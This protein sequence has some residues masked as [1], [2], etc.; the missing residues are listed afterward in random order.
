MRNLMP[1]HL[2]GSVYLG[3]IVALAF[4]LHH[5]ASPLLPFL[6]WFGFAALLSVGVWRWLE[7]KPIHWS[8]S[9]RWVLI[10]AL[11]FHAVAL[12]VPPFMEDDYFRYLWDGY[13]TYDTGQ[14]YGIPPQWYFGNETLSPRLQTL[15]DNINYPSIP[16]IYGPFAQ[17]LFALAYSLGEGALWA[18]RGIAFLFT[19]VYCLL[20]YRLFPG[21]RSI[22]LLWHPLLIREFS[23]AMH[24]DIVMGV[25]ML[26]A[27]WAWQKQQ[28]FR[29]GLTGAL[30][31]ATKVIAVPVV[32][33]LAVR[34]RSREQ[35]HQ[36]IVVGGVCFFALVGLYGVFMWQ[37]PASEWAGLWSFASGFE[38]NSSGYALLKWSLGIE[39]AR[40]ISYVL[41]GLGWLWVWFKLWRF[42]W[43]IPMALFWG[44]AWSWCWL[45]VVNPWYLVVWL[46]WLLSQ[47]A[48]WPW[49]FSYLIVLSY[50]TGMYW[51]Q[52]MPLPFTQQPLDLYQHPLWL[53][54]L[55]FL[56]VLLVG[57]WE[58]WRRRDRM[59]FETFQH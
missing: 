16:T 46:P 59:V 34:E 52:D 31:I 18:W 8:V 33:A 56:P 40:P 51:P 17:A 15:L 32:I 22:L 7:R 42:R 9:G 3:S 38:F 5:G 57:C 48:V 36:T 1:L 50:I 10:W 19:L 11:L 27:Y 2:A 6:A 28:W 29:L 58:A 37:A 55:E 23:I 39:S 30:L 49:L 35:W 41:L 45:P 26:L 25:L 43:S 13:L 53:R 14:P 47:R 4:S 12:G 21:N 54:W 24:L 44:Y 20:V